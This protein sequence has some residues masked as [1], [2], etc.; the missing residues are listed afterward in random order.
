M[1]LRTAW[2]DRAL[3]GISRL[4]HCVGSPDSVAGASSMPG[5]L[6]ILLNHPLWADWELFRIAEDV[7]PAGNQRRLR[8][9]YDVGG[10]LRECGQIIPGTRSSQA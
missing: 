10:I 1:C 7:V 8:I 9:C 4:E 2:Y 6:Q 5:R 3:K